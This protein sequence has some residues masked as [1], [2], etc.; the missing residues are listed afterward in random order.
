V[1]KRAEEI[2][3]LRRASKTISHTAKE[4]ERVARSLVKTRAQERAFL[5]D[6]IRTIE[7]T[8]AGESSEL[9]ISAP[10]ASENELQLER[11][12]RDD[13]LLLEL[14]R[15]IGGSQTD[16]DRDEDPHLEIFYDE[17]AWEMVADDLKPGAAGF[18]YLGGDPSDAEIEAFKEALEAV[19]SFDGFDHIEWGESS[20]GSWWQKFRIWMSPHFAKSDIDTGKRAAEAFLLDQQQAPAAKSYSDAISSLMTASAG[21]DVVHIATKNV[22]FLKTVRDGKSVAISRT[23]TSTEVRLYEAGELHYVLATPESAYRFI[24]TGV[25]ERALP[26]ARSEQS[27]DGQSI[28]GMTPDPPAAIGPNPST[29]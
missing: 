13:E 11:A 24:T 18:L 1:W 14:E 6:L 10:Q 22:V 4:L 26:A 9:R 19:V 23:L 5:Q 2:N 20:R 12:A 29:P 7:I 17:K 28:E 25:I 27:V 21:I 3:R 8:A 15:E 16:I